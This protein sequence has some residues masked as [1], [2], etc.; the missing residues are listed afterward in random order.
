MRSVVDV[1]ATRAP[2]RASMRA[3]A[4]PIPASLP[5]PVTRAARPERSKGV[6]FTYGIRS[7]RRQPWPEPAEAL[8]DDRVGGLTARRMAAD[9]GDELVAL[10]RQE[11]S[12]ASGSHRGG[13]RHVAE[14]R[15]LAE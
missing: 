7:D 12:V 13:A 8:S 14:Q 1:I 11:R 9:C 2:R 3:Q 10:E 6:A 15:D 4:N 5:Q